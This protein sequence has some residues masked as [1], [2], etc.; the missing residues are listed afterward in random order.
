MPSPSKLAA[1]RG[2]PKLWP[3]VALGVCGLVA[4]ACFFVAERQDDVVWDEAWADGRLTQVT[5]IPTEDASALEFFA[6]GDTGSNSPERARVVERMVDTARRHPP[7]FIFLLGDNFYPSGIDTVDDPRWQ[8]DFEDCFA[9][10]VLQVPFFA[11]LGNHD[12]RGDIAA[13][14]AYTAHSARWRMPS[15]SYVFEHAIDAAGHRAAFFVIDSTPLDEE[16]ASD[17]LAAWLS[18]ELARSTAT[19]RIVVCHHPLLSHGVHG[20]TDEVIDTIGSLL[21]RHEVQLVISGHDH[22]LQFLRASDGWCQ[23]VSGAGSET[24]KTSIGTGTVFAASE[25]GF[26]RLRLGI[27]SAYVQVVSAARGACA[28]YRLERAGLVHERAPA[29]SARDSDAPR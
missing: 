6:V 25:P 24:R 26:F 21:R 10:P 15:R 9:D 7:A 20:A 11:A 1:L 2:D 12:H 22:D 5:D 27:E 19:W 4:V 14:I 18:S 17:E 16:D 28:T 23:I 3:T 29:A 13:Q 8:V